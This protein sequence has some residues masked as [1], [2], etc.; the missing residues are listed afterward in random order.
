MIKVDEDKLVEVIHEG[1]EKAFRIPVMS[2]LDW[3]KYL[4]KI[5]QEN[6]L[7]MNDKDLNKLF[8]AVESYVDKKEEESKD[9]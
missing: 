2:T 4:Y 8:G 6:T 3:L 9:E 5:I 1:M 7:E